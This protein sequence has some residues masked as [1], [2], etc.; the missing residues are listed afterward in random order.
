MVRKNTQLKPVPASEMKTWEE[1]MNEAGCELA[2]ITMHPKT[3]QAIRSALQSLIVN[4]ISNES[5]YQWIDDEEALVFLLPRYLNHMDESYA[6]GLIH[7]ASEIIYDTCPAEVRRDAKK[8]ARD[9][10]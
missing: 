3:P 4:I 5:G 2:H 9:N 10:G 1:C 7:A 6:K 8:E